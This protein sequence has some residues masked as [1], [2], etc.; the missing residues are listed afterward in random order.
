MTWDSGTSMYKLIYKGSA[1]S[2][3]FCYMNPDKSYTTQGLNDAQAAF[4][5]DD[6]QPNPWSD[7]YLQTFDLLMPQDVGEYVY[8]ATSRY[9]GDALAEGATITNQDD[10]DFGTDKLFGYWES[11]DASST[12]SY[13]ATA[14]A[15][16]DGDNGG[17]VTAKLA[18]STSRN[19]KVTRYQ[20]TTTTVKMDGKSYTD[21][22]NAEI[23][24]DREIILTAAKE[25]DYNFDGW[26]YNGEKVSG[27]EII[28][29]Q[30]P[31]DSTGEVV[32]TAKFV[33]KPENWQLK[34]GVT[35]ES[36]WSTVQLTQEGNTD[37]Y[38]G[39]LTM[40]EGQQHN[41]QIY[42][43]MRDIWYAN[44]ATYTN[45]TDATIVSDTAL[46][47]GKN[48][49]TLRAHAGTY[50]FKMNSDTHKLTITASYS[51]ITITFDYSDQTWW[52]NDSAVISFYDGSGESNMSD[53]DGKTKTISISS[54]RGNS[55]DVG[56]NR[57]NNDEHSTHWDNVNAGARGYK[58]TYK[59][60]TGWQ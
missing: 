37:I 53:G 1:Q 13:H 9:I 40:T 43:G 21:S 39:T 11:A 5:E 41:F 7:K 49:M 30:I 28:T 46:E 12:K 38:S 51:N 14:T 42:D 20:T 27:Q 56:F 32:Y 55:G 23:S 2:V 52:E 26:Y 29:T 4:D 33:K 44:G 34:Y 50:T 6:T 10:Y 25:S 16:V 19:D 31:E 57:W 48:D 24:Y 22:Q 58:T 60:G 18:H 8:H 15:K 54:S 45:K 47:S 3:I 35:D 17:T 59:V 36:N